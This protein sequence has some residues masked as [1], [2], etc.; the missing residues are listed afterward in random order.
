MRIDK[1]YPSNQCDDYGKLASKSFRVVSVI[2]TFEQ[3]VNQTYVF[4][5]SKL[6]H[7]AFLKSMHFRVIERSIKNKHFRE[8]KKVGKFSFVLNDRETELYGFNMYPKKIMET[9]L[10]EVA[11]AWIKN[12]I[13]NIDNLLITDFRIYGELFQSHTKEDLQELLEEINK[14]RNY[15]KRTKRSHNE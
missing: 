2:E 12:A 3:F 7:T 14:R 8:L 4:G 13:K 5:P 1:N 9:D 6:Y 15:S 10:K 11:V